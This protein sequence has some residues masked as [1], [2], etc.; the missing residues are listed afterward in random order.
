MS[1]PSRQRR[2][3]QAVLDEDRVRREEFVSSV[4]LRQPPHNIQAEQ[5]L[6]GALLANNR[7]YERIA[8][9]LKP[10]H[11][12]DPVHAA[13]Y[14]QYQIGV[15]AG[16]VMDAVTMADHFR[17]TEIL[18]DAGG[19]GYLAQLLTAMV[20]IVSVPEYARAIYDAWVRRQLIET[21]AQLFSDAY[22][23]NVDAR[24]RAAL[25]VSRIDMSLRA[26]GEGNGASGKTLLEAVDEALNGADEAASRG[27]PVGLSTGFPAIDRKILGLRDGGYYVLAARP[28]MGKTALAV[29]IAERAALTCRQDATDTGTKG[30]V[31]VIS[32]EMP[33]ADLASRFLAYRSG[34]PLENLLKGEHADYVDALLAARE[35]AV[36]LPLIIED[37]PGL[38]MAEILL[39]VRSA[40]RRLGQVRLIVLDHMHIVRPDEGQQGTWAVGQTSNAIKRMAK[41]FNCPVL[42]L[43]QLSRAV[44]GRDDKRPNLSDLRQAGEI[45]QDADA[46]MFLY[47][48]EYYLDQVPVPTRKAGESL[49]AFTD[50][51]DKDAQERQRA[52]GKAELICAKLRQGK[53][54]T[55]YLGWH[56]AT[57]SFRGD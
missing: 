54:G 21:A 53:P 49:T 9:F 41:E 46:V 4:A 17:N 16:R 3:Y 57:T 26:P 56:G 5:A 6:L 27:G 23:G 39:K 12:I 18:T 13:I 11:F 40:A 52:A 55:V 38:R 30:G 48:E 33:A 8:H 47:R 35:S 19:T 42:A 7:A 31:V 44:E 36:S 29:Q 45:E 14:A 25:A 50:R 2:R 10:E 34:M 15:E 24:D 20:G 28:G 51:L 22:A 32:M 37:V 1:E 43:A